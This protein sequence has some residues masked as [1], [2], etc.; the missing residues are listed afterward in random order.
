MPTIELGQHSIEVSHGDRIVFPDV[1]IT[2]QDVIDYYLWA[3]EYMAPHVRGRP[4]VMLRFPNGLDGDHFFQKQ[5]S[6]HFPDWISRV[7]LPRRS[8]GEVEHAVVCDDAATIVYVANQ[9]AFELHTLL[10]DGSRP[11]HPDQL[12]LDLDPSTDELGPVIGA[13]RTVREV[14]GDLDVPSFVKSTGSRGVHVHLPLD[15]AVDIDRVH[16]VAG[17]LADRVAEQD[18]GS[19]TTAH[20]KKD[21]GDRVFVDWL[22]NGYGQHAVAPYSVRARPGAPVAVPM[23]WSEVTDSGFDPRRYTIRNV[24]RRLAQKDDPW[25]GFGTETCDADALRERLARS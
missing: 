18:P 5:A 11:E 17:V 4:L 6:D 2:K 22:R 14:L 13:A 24:R 15:G 25:L 23:D 1:G 9:G 21:R 7:E 19:L 3:A 10:V 8:G 16:D 12:I 20:A